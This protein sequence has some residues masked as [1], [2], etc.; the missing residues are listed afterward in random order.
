M[1]FVQSPDLELK[2]TKKQQKKQLL[3]WLCNKHF[4]KVCKKY[5]VVFQ[6]VISTC[7][8]KKKTITQ[9][10]I[11][12]FSTGVCLQKEIRTCGNTDLFQIQTFFLFSSKVDKK[13]FGTRLDTRNIQHNDSLFA[14]PVYWKQNCQVFIC[15]IPRVK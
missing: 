2:K 5:G 1:S 6:N 14:C 8:E 10:L 12:C 13:H 15:Y 11:C 9:V 4:F 3:K 7:W